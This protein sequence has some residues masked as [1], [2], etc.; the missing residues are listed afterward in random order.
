[1][2]VTVVLP[3]YNER[4]NITPLLTELRRVVP[5]ALIV[6]ID[7]QS[8]DGTGQAAQECATQLG[9]IQVLHRNSKDGLGSAYRYG[10]RWVF[11]AADDVAPDVGRPGGE[12]DIVV[13]MDADFSHDPSVIPQLID[14]I[15]GGADAV[16]GSRYVK[17]GNTVDWPLHR[18][19]LSR[20][21][22]VYTGFILGV[23]VSDCTSGFRAYRLDALRGI[24]PQ[25]TSAEGYAFLTELIV[26]LHR[27]GKI[28]AEVPIT[29][30]DRKYG[31]SKMSRHIIVES[32]RLVTVWGL[33]HRIVQARHWLWRKRR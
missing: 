13:T 6:V 21:G 22:N 28:I 31:I 18:R 3:T 2:S 24:A 32:M 14:A 25:T 8:P 16:V 27:Q 30:S 11:T 26:R 15:N 12:V 7:D 9:H 1:M 20:W 4:E 29:F 10:F 33:R 19:L 5:Q 17:G 23:G